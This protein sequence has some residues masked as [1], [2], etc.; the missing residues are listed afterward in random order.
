MI[1]RFLVTLSVVVFLC[2]GSGRIDASDPLVD[3]WNAPPP[4]ARLR[5]YWWWLN[6]YVTKEAITRDLEEMKAKGFAG[7]LLC[8]ADGSAQDGNERAPHGPD[9]LS[10]QWLALYRHTLQEAD[11]LGLEISLNIQSGWNLGGPMVSAEDAAK[12]LTWSEFRV[13][14]PRTIEVTLPQP[15]LR[16]DFYRDAFVVAYPLGEREQAEKAFDVVASSAQP[17]HP[18]SLILDGKESTFWVSD[19]TSPATGPAPDRPQWIEFRF[20]EPVRIGQVIVLPRENYG[21]H[22]CRLELVDAHD[23]EQVV[24]EFTCRKAGE[25]QITFA[26]HEAKRVRLVIMGAFDRGST[27]APRNVQIAELRMAGPD[28]V[29]PSNRRPPIR[30]WAE[31]AGYKPLHF[32]APDTSL[33]FE[34]ESAAPDEEDTLA[35]QV[36]DLSER[37]DENGV[38]RWDVP[39]G[40]WNVLRFGY[41]VSDR[42]YVSTCS[43]GWEGFAIDVLDE[44]AFRRYWD[45]VVAKLIDEAGPYAGKSLRYL[46]TD[47]WEVEPLNWTPTLPDE[48]RRRRGYSMLPWMPVLAG[49]IVENR[50]ASNRFLHDFRKTIGELA[51]DHHYRPFREG[52]HRHGLQIHP[53]SGGPHAVP[54]DAQRCLGFNDIPMSEFWAWSW[55]HRIGDAN[56]FFVKQPASA[57]HTYGRIRVAAEGFTTIGPHWQ[58]TL[59]DNLKPS[60]DKACCEGF[61]MLFWHAFVCS[62]RECGLP[63]IQYF[64]GTHL[65]PNVTW[66]EKSKPF[67]DYINRCQ[68]M[69]QQGLFVADVLYYYGDHVPNFAQHKR[70][71]P[72]GILPGYDYDVITE[73]AL[74][75]RTSVREGRIV[76]PDGMSYRVLVLPPRDRISLAALRKVA[77]LVR[78]GAVVVGPRPVAG[79]G[80]QDDDEEIRSIAAELWDT[81]RVRTVSAREVLASLGVPPDFMY[82][83]A[84]EEADID[85]IHRRT[86]DADIYFVADRGKQPQRLRCA[87]RVHG[88]APELWNPVTGERKFAATYH[89]TETHTEV[90]LDLSPCGSWFV[91]FREPTTQHPPAA[92]KNG[93]RIVD[94]QS[95]EGPWQVTF[96]RNWGGPGTVVFDKLVDWTSRP[97]RGIRYYSGTAVYRKSFHVDADVLASQHRLYLDL[98]AVRELAEVKLNGRPC[99][100]VWAPPFRVD[101]TKALKPGENELTVEVVNFW[102]NRIIG[103][104]ALPPDERRTHT[105]V[106]KL[107][108]DTDLMPSGLFGPVRLQSSGD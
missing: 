37:V 69:L 45:A 19:S 4:E 65:N 32:S 38:L 42:A 79:E 15:A 2:A 30:H 80:L 90:E 100:I 11:R 14:G 71:D 72:A 59:W 58:E 24:T 76:L 84:S 91:V 60:F 35:E 20:A 74:L 8:D 34:M 18:A 88:K 46:H 106:R 77:E 57:A 66:W 61:N 54:I 96:A 48:F 1:L 52:A 41:T 99:G 67:F 12:K 97:E 104:A 63:G 7:A 23:R 81:G 16:E 44:G 85:Y 5:A 107:T 55:R 92:G 53:E 83:G 103:D 47:S 62:P 68:F 51:I 86:P 33:L 56:R 75:T 26:P 89:E 29:F 31:K 49:K 40:T 50:E 28:G 3:G 105:N 9:F 101:V 94:R 21:P 39:Q 36:V 10:D 43:E 93:P 25:T 64:A 108:A 95:I 102:P 78:D 87:F 13:E 73:E 22:A 82:T 98:G 17:S 70:T 6:G 27:E